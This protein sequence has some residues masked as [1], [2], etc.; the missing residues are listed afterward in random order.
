MSDVDAYT[1]I[2]KL[3]NR[4]WVDPDVNKS[5]ADLKQYFEEHQKEYSSIEKFKAQVER[6]QL[7]WGPCHTEEFW[8]QNAVL[9]EKNTDYMKLIDIIVDECLTSPHDRV[10][11]VACYD[12]GEFA[13]LCHRGK[14]TLDAKDVRGKM[15]AMMQDPKAS[16]EVKKEAITC[17]QKILMDAWTANSFKDA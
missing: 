17:Y 2:C 5:L 1:L 6:R 9:F 10:K 11:A 4:Y 3:E 14:Q 13:K 12:L 15:T 8:K 7:K 16:A